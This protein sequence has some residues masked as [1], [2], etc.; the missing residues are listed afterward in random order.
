MRSPAASGAVIPAVFLSA[1][2][3]AGCGPQAS[4]PTTTGGPVAVSWTPPT[5]TD[6]TDANP[7]VGCDPA[8]GSQFPVGATTVTCTATDEAGNAQP[9]DPPWNYGGFMN[10]TPHRVRVLVR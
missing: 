1:L 8:S 7:S 10:N 5:A 4:P 2:L 9:M 6:D 3:L